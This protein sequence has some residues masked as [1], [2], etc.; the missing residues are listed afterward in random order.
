MIPS[1]IYTAS[2]SIWP[3]SAP[4]A[5]YHAANA[6]PLPRSLYP[7]PHHARAPVD[8]HL[9]VAAV[10]VYND[11]RDWG[12]DLTLLVDLLL[13]HRG[14]L[15]TLSGLNGRADLPNRG[16]LQDAQPAVAF[17]N[18]DLW[19]AA[20]Y[21]LSRLGQGG[22][23]AAL[24][25]AWAAATRDA[26]HGAAPLQ[27]P[28]GKVHMMGKPHTATYAF[29]ERRLR[30]GRARLL[31]ESAG[32]PAATA[33]RRV[34]MVGDNPAS[35]IAGANA[36]TAA[37]K[38]AKDAATWRS[39]LVRSGVYGGGRPAAEPEVVVDDVR[40]AVRWS[41]AE[42]GWAVGEGELDGD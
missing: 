8:S 16:F 28:L 9:R 40:E 41:L 27:G 31:G 32:A 20:A 13:S 29:A 18:P 3:F 24:E 17:S 42:E 21:H 6:R 10:H 4:F 1:D 14:V 15:G 35:D 12:L 19:W 11:P 33:L 23:K 26:A 5:A 25:G 22:F 7:G 39:V 2:P 34:Y 30:Q 36:W 37:S 38:A